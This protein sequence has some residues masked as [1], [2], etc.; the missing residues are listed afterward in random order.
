MV[1]CLL[2]I[3]NEI[4]FSDEQIKPGLLAPEIGDCGSASALLSLAIVLDQ[5]SSGENILLVSYG[6][7]A[8]C[9]VLGLK[10]TNLLEEAK[11]RRQIYPSVRKMINDKEYI[12]YLQYLKQERKLLQEYI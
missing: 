8:G 12:S 2:R 9:D 6:F 1:D 3:L 7:G 5:A 10:T 4:G 11:G